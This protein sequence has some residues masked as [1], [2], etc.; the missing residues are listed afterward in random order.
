MDEAQDQYSK[1][2]KLE[3]HHGFQSPVYFQSPFSC[4]MKSMETENRLVAACPE[5]GTG[6]RLL[7]DMRLF[8][9]RGGDENDLELDWY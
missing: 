7:M 5:A 3:E 9:G 6:E 2:K 1:G 4:N 8:R